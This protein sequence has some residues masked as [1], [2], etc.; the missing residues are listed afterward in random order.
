MGF[1]QHQAPSVTHRR[2]ESANPKTIQDAREKVGRDNFTAFL[3]SQQEGGGLKTTPHNPGGCPV[4]NSPSQL[5]T[6]TYNIL[7]EG[8]SNNRRGGL[9]NIYRKKDI[10]LIKFSLGDCTNSRPILDRSE[11]SFERPK[12]GDRSGNRLGGGIELRC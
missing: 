10:C 6:G 5:K 11:S 1:A 7:L 2:H 3:F 9:A 4:G 8:I 12:R